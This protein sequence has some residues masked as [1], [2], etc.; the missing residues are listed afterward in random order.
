[1]HI[2]GVR[3]VLSRERPLEGL[4]RMR[5]GAGSDSGELAAEGDGNG[6]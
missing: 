2:K 3:F 5:A 4:Q 6:V 1:M